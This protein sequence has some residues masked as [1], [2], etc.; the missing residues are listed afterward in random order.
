MS[1]G[2]DSLLN[3]A[4]I[5]FSGRATVRTRFSPLFHEIAI[6]YAGM[7]MRPF[8]RQCVG[9]VVIEAV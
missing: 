8:L 4:M 3:A 9:C 1:I 5:S 6:R 2:N 7:S